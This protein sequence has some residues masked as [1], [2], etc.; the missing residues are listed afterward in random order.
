MKIRTLKLF[1][2]IGTHR[3]AFTAMASRVIQAMG[4]LAAIPLITTHLSAA[5]Q[6]YY[7]TF[8]S[9]AALQ[10]FVELGMTGVI[11]QSLAHEVAHLNLNVSV[12]DP[13]WDGP[14]YHRARFA[15]VLRFAKWWFGLAGICSSIA[16]AIGGA[17]FMLSAE[18]QHPTG[19][20]WIGP[21]LTIAIMTG[22]IVWTAGVM[23]I[24][25]G[26]GSIGTAT[27]IRLIA[28]VSGLAGLILG[29]LLGIGL[30]SIAINM[31]LI[32]IISLG[33][34]WWWLRRPLKAITSQPPDHQYCWKTEI[35]PFQWRIALSWMAGWFIFQAM[36]P[37]MLRFSGAEAAGRFGLALQVANGVQALAGVWTQ[38]RAPAWGMMIAKSEW[39][40]LDRDFRKWVLISIGFSML[41]AIIVIVGMEWILTSTL[42]IRHRLPS[43]AVMFPLL[44]V[45]ILNQWVFA[46]AGYL[47]AH[48]KEPFL[49]TSITTALTILVA[50]QF[51]GLVKES[52]LP[53]TYGIVSLVVGGIVGTIIWRRCRSQ[54]HFAKNNE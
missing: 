47:R 16:L 33:A 32:V 28:S 29:L 49:G 38:I 26:I 27:T 23:S 41:G 42:E 22:G 52:S 34:G 51:P 39:S 24:L 15:A 44:S 30:W 43:L 3:I 20:V 53:T 14:V 35:W 4:W 12:S 36:T 8:A 18:N 54:W 19:V 13:S 6:G 1:T 17:W 21:W 37:A 7:Y 10:V 11:V 5:E 2:W 25:E 48:K 9:L 45:A 46:I 50:I 40:V 31:G